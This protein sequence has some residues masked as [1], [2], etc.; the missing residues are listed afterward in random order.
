MALPKA[1]TKANE[2]VAMTA[3]RWDILMVAHSET[4]TVDGMVDRTVDWMVVW[5][6]DGMVEWTVGMT[7]VT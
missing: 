3:G 2:S 6:V 5:M 7:A 4:R 1:V